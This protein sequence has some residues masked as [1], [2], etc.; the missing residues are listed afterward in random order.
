LAQDSRKGWVIRCDRGKISSIVAVS[1]K[2]LFAKR[3]CSGSPD[4]SAFRLFEPRNANTADLSAA[5]K[6]W[7]NAYGMSVRRKGEIICSVFSVVY[8]S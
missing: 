4:F 5:K 2:I 6:A 7:L 8:G 3:F 1:G